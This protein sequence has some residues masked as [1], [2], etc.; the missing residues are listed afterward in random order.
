MKL[1]VIPDP[2]CWADA[3]SVPTDAGIPSRLDDWRRAAAE[4]VRIAETERPDAVL[5]TGD[6]FNTPRPT[7]AALLAVH[8]FFRGFDQVA[9]LV[10]IEGNH[11]CPGGQNP[12]P[13]KVLA[14][15]RFSLNW[16][17]TTPGVLGIDTKD[18]LLCLAHLPW[19]RPSGNL[20]VEAA[21]TA[22]E[23]TARGLAAAADAM[24]RDSR[25]KGARA[26]AVLLGHWAVSGS[27]LSS[28][29]LMLG[30][31]PTLRLDALQALPVDAVLMGHIHRPQVWPGTPGQALVLHA[32]AIQ[33]R[34]FGEETDDRGV[35][36]I[37]MGA[38]QP[39]F[40]SFVPVG[41]RDFETVEEVL[42]SPDD[43][44]GMLCRC[45]RV[46]A[47]A[48]VRV[49]YTCDA[50][51]ASRVDH[52][53][54]R[55]RV[56]SAGAQQLAGIYPEVARPDRVRVAGLTETTDPMTAFD[57][58]LGARADLPEALRAPLRT[59]AAEIM[60][61]AGLLRPGRMAQEEAEP[62]GTPAPDPA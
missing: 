12:S 37:D 44:V 45:E 14:Q 19:Q 17:V 52:D 3:Y 46:P 7:P 4:I 24:A 13:L 60:A 20:S 36:I 27:R 43:L 10:C 40:T 9:P 54:I 50:A 31:E 26:H 34:D 49:R 38:G 23:E 41:D 56:L 62:V 33:R 57:A 5:C 21:G 29:T 51:M 59:G 47:G 16:A 11:T 55:R 53:D 2:H 42:A 22:L 1:L 25:L 35:W 39:T 61:E 8:W 28:G 15:E 18:G 32:G 58:W 6:V 48:I 30:G